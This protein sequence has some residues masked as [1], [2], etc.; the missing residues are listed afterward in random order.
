MVMKSTFNNHITDYI[1]YED[2]L[3][4]DLKLE[5]DYYEDL[6]DVEVL[7]KYTPTLEK[8]CKDLGIKEY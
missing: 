4:E 6:Y 7:G 8:I 3:N 1:S 2:E 5:Q